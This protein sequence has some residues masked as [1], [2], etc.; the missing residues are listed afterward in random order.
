VIASEAEH[1]FDLVKMGFVCLLLLL[2]VLVFFNAVVVDA[3][4]VCC[5]FFDN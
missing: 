5:A 1:Q 2:V 4:K 3:L